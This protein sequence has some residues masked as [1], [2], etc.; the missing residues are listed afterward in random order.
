MR[1]VVASLLI[2]NGATMAQIQPIMGWMN[3]Q[4]AEYYTHLSQKFGRETMNKIPEILNHETPD[5]INFLN[6][7]H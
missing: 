2:E 1:H 6:A 7:M 5:T 3:S 4:M